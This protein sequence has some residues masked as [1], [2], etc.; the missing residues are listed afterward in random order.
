MYTMTRRKEKTVEQTT[1]ALVQSGSTGLN[2]NQD[3]TTGTL[4]VLGS[5]GCI[6]RFGF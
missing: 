4:T 6:S 3:Q 5:I 2:Q 1:V